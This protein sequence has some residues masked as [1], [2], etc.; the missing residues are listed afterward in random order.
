MRD[1]NG[2]KVIAVDNGYGNVKTANTVTPT[3]LVAYDTKPIFSGSILSGESR[4]DV[5]GLQRA[6]PPHQGEESGVPVTEKG[7]GDAFAAERV[8]A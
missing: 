5:S 7:T 3:G 4:A 6:C 8:Q 2:I 1:F